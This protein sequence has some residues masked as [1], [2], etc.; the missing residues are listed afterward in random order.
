[1]LRCLDEDEEGE[2]KEK[3]FFFVGVEGVLRDG[4]ELARLPLLGA[5]DDA[6]G[7]VKRSPDI[8]IAEIESGQ[9]RLHG[10]RRFAPSLT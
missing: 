2:E 7:W 10:R 1:M 8:G 5:D 4:F 9:A 3:R 6:A